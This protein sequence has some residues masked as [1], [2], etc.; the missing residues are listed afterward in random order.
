MTNKELDALVEELAKSPID[1]REFI[2]N[3]LEEEMNDDELD[4]FVTDLENSPL[5]LREFILNSLD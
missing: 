2:L 5:D 3:A 4:D 1:L